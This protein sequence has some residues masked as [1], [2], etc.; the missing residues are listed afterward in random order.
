MRENDIEDA[1]IIG[2]ASAPRALSEAVFDGHRLAREID[3][4]NPAM[5]LPFIRER[6]RWDGGAVRLRRRKAR[7]PPFDEARDSLRE[8]GPSRGSGERRSRLVV[9]RREIHRGSIAELLLDIRNGGGRAVS[10][11][12]V[13]VAH[14]LLEH[15][16]ARGHE[17]D[18][19][20][21]ARPPRR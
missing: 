1:W 19:A 21:L 16:L 10:R 9:A 13:R 20:D 17:L 5:A 18:Q 8:V 6:V 15:V 14:G 11:Q 4:P 12:L 2:D 7:L 3:S